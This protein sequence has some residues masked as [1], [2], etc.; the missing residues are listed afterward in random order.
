MH[1]Q[2]L[3]RLKMG[4]KGLCS[5]RYNK[6]SHAGK[7]QGPEKKL[8]VLKTNFDTSIISPEAWMCVSIPEP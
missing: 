6:V 4:L 7:H 1:Q 3:S 8:H 2:K 5:G